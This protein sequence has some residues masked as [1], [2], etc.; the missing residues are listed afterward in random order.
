MNERIIN[1]CFKFNEN[2]YA[3]DDNSL[4]YRKSSEEEVK[5]LDYYNAFTGIYNHP[6]NGENVFKFNYGPSTGGIIETLDFQIYTYG[7]RILS[8][9]VIPE[10]KKR[11]LKVSGEHINMGLLK[12][13]RFNGFHSFSYSTLY[14]A[15]VERKMGI[16]IEEDSRN[17]RIILLE[18]ERIISHIFKTARLCEAAS[19]NIATYA[20]LG[21]REKLMR[22]LAEKAGHR[23][24]FGINK[25]GGIGRK[26]D[27][28]GL[29]KVVRDIV[30]QYRKIKEG[31]F[32]SRIFIDRIENT[33]IANFGF[34]RGPTLRSTGKKYDYRMIDPYYSDLDFEP[35]VSSGGDS[36]TRFLVFSQEVDQS[37]EIIEQCIDRKVSGEWIE[38]ASNKEV[39]GIETP[40]GDA[41]M[42]M[43][44][45]GEKIGFL[46]LRTPSVLNM[47]AFAR[48]IRGNV[49]TDI[50]FA[51]ESFG[52]WVS[53]MS[54]VI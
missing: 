2:V 20:L 31:L 43:E 29:V 39:F 40:S 50:P 23:Y 17:Q 4:H 19:Q 13:E 6:V 9:D 22:T 21:L 47:E 16:P 34:S 54:D 49:K 12:L 53:E 26:L 52:I 14:S 7:E 35:V 37:M 51:L 45:E 11:I 33:C 8:L 1:G 46:Y 32:V 18:V 48:G 5:S 25:I 3:I 42:A 27:M 44:I 30:D 28:D 10:Y 36:L 41:R 15:A 24:L 38:P